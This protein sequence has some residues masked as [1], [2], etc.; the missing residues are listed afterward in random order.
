MNELGDSSAEEHRRIGELCDGV[1]LSWVITVGDEANKYL[2][3]A[4]KAKG[5]QVK[6]SVKML[7]RLGLSLIKSF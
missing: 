4:A 7:S 3:P 5:C 1:E 6:I 2:A